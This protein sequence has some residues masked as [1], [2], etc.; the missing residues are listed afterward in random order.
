MSPVRD[1]SSSG[2]DH[3]LEYRLDWGTALT[4]L[5]QG[6]TMEGPFRDAGAALRLFG[7]KDMG[8]LRTP[9]LTS[10]TA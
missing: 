4:L 6:Q 7:A 1:K 10:V 9:S 2:A 8:R 3:H 5:P